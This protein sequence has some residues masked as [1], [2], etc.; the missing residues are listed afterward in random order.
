METP[1]NP[2]TALIEALLPYWPYAAAFAV[3][4]LA[5]A[6]PMPGRGPNFWARRD[7]WR[8]FKYQPRRTVL[9]NAGGQCEGSRF[10]AWG[11][12]KADATEVD[13]IYPWSRRGP[14]VVSNGQALCKGHNRNKSNMRPPWWY[15]RAL[16]RRRR[17]YFPADADWHVLAR[18][19]Q[20]D[21]AARQKKPAN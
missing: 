2:L 9:S 6:L 5:L 1:T 17:G 21:A 14:T 15:V 4:L 8:G 13:H 7:P 10:L 16:E 19:S 20:A 3:V 11:R 18:M 12:C